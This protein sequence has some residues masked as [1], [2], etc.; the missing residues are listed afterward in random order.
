MNKKIIAAV[1]AVLLA[2][3]IIV[4]CVFGVKAYKQNQIAE[5]LA[6]NNTDATDN[7][8]VDSKAFPKVLG[9]P[10]EWE[11]TFRDDFDFLDTT[12]WKV[13]TFEENNNIRKGAYYT[14]EEDVLFTKDGKLHIRT[15]WK[16]GKN[17]KGWYT[18]YLETSKNI[19]NEYNTENFEGFSQVDG[20]F[21]IRCKVPAVYGMW[22]AFWMMPENELAFREGGI[23]N[24]AEDGLEIDIM[25]SPYFSRENKEQK[26]SIKHVLHADGYGETKKTLATD[27]I[28]IPTLYNEY[29]TF[30]VLWEGDK[31]TFFIDGKQ[32]WTTRHIVDGVKMG[33]CLTPEYLILSTE[34][35][36]AIENGKVHEGKVRDGNG[37]WIDNWS[38]D[39]SMNSKKS[40][41]D[42]IVEYVRCYKKK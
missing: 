22:S 25:E 8:N 39:S 40:G 31:Y 5:L 15:T 9:N 26:Y 1:I 38:G 33:P 23:L 10:D 28:Y 41:H 24:S 36:A 17:G 13:I 27:H 16:E 30:A 42:F 18:S 4:G 35:G 3:L 19:D 11:E 6:K 12:K 20:Y 14:D 29:H 37:K 34:V 32:T 2:V 21:E 7:A